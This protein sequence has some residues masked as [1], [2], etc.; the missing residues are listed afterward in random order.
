MESIDAHV[1]GSVGVL[2]NHGQVLAR[3]EGIKTQDIDL[4]GT[5]DPVV[6][7]GVSE[8]EGKHT[9]L[10]QVGLVD[11]GEAADDDGKTTE[12]TGLKGSVLTRRSLTVVV[13]TDDDP[14]DSFVA[15]GSSNFGD[16]TVSSIE[17]IQDV[18]GLAVLSVD[19][20]DEAVL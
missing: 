4:V 16:R 20:T 11:T 12:E 17:L 10:L 14:L 5:L 15:V 6:V 3:S 2:G 19:G 13:V 7:L 8:G 9:L 1:L 18:V